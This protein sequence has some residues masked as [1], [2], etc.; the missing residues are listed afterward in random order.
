MSRLPILLVLV[1]VLALVP[2][3]RTNAIQGAS[4]ELFIAPTGKD[5]NPCTLSQP[6]QTMNHVYDKASPGEIVGM[7][8]GSYPAQS[9][10][11]DSSKTS[12]ADV[13]FMPA[14]GA[15]VTVTSAIYVFAS[16]ITIEN[17]KV[18]NVT[19][20][21]YDQ[22]LGRPDPT[23]VTL[24]G[25][26]GRNF[27]IDSATNV[28]VEGGSWGPASACG[29]P[30]GGGNNSIRQPTGTAPAN[31]VIDK[32]VIH[33]VQSYNL[34]EC[35]I[36]GLAIF[37]GTKV[38]VSN[39]TFY[40]NSV[41][42]IFMQSN[43][44]GHPNNVTLSNNWLA[45]AVDD[46]GANGRSV[47]SHN[48][49]A[50]GDSGINENLT[51]QGNQM[52]DVLQ[53]DDNGTKGA[54]TNV[55]VAENV[56][57]MPYSNY[58]CGSLSGIQ[59]SENIWQN[60]K[61]GGSDVDLNGA[62]MPY[63]KATNDA[64]LDYTLTGAYA[65]W[66]GSAGGTSGEG[67]SGGGSS[68]GAVASVFVSPSGSD[69]AACSQGAPC[70]T[71]A[72]AYRVAQ[73]GATVQLASGTYTDTTLPMDSSKGTA[74]VVFK[75]AS[76][77][78]ATFSSTL[79]LQA[80]HVEL[81]GLKFAT[82][83]VEASAQNDILRNDTYKNFEVI[84]SGTQAPTNISFIGG[85]A[86]PAA[87]QNNIIGSNGTS[88][89]ASPTNI[90]IQGVHIHDY[91]L[92]PGSGAHVDC[93]QVWAANGL[94]VTGSTFNDCE[95]FDI[96]LQ[97]LPGGSAGTPR[98]VT[99][100]NNYLD[101]CRSGYYS[102]ML[103]YHTGSTGGSH[104]TNVTVRNN[105][106]DKPMT[107]DPDATYTNVKFDGNIGPS[108][109]FYSN[110]KDTLQGEPAGVSA[111]YNVWYA[112]KKIGTHDQVAPSGFIEPSKL[113]F[114]L[115]EGAAALNHG[116]PFDYPATDIYGKPRPNPPDAGATQH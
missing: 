88:T 109:V 71:L 23:D 42:D 52:N 82:L 38:T 43:S 5:S 113:N 63:K 94:T 13:V 33:D 26:T 45:A 27:Q 103:P 44:G 115:K 87:N 4:A 111:D 114:N 83:W 112:G 65:N 76:G 86:G 8:A 18:Q 41:Y 6:C 90:L 9:I 16:H 55:K 59:W 102:I 37:A 10:N 34:V 53:M 100:Q 60:D 99:I 35:H 32:T 58:P 75:V 2:S 39:S 1:L 21:N 73:S 15:S 20:G 104:F 70:R 105:S 78:T 14:E 85:S 95:V 28:T 84:S 46:S 11:G 19:I 51:V 17:M 77:A 3:V 48:G 56:G 7:L 80:H 57:M 93:L 61:C 54:Y 36:E 98:N 107:A 74:N 67:S 69:T 25:L 89:T 22:T 29:G 79:H 110:A 68:T 92:T 24:Q 108:L 50:V 31:I 72:R 81:S 12:S 30:Y 49:V 62:A 96:F 66:P 101:C 47:G 97:F 40:G 116:D 91:T 106:T 64:T